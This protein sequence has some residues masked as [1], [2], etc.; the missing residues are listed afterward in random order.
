[1]SIACGNGSIL[2]HMIPTPCKTLWFRYDYSLY[3][4]KSS[5][6]W[7]ENMMRYDFSIADMKWS[8]VQTR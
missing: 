2:A 1:M 4:V 5:D 6:C 3:N 8:N 7:V